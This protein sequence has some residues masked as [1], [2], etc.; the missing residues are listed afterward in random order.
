MHLIE[1]YF[2]WRNY[3]TAE[4]DAQSPFYGREYSEFEFHHKVYNYFIHP[5]WDEFGS[6]TLYA[7]IIFAD[8]DDSCAIVELIGEWNDTLYNDIMLFKR[9]L[10]DPMMKRGIHKFVLIGENVLNFH[11]SDDDYYM[12]WQEECMD[13]GGWIAAFNFQQH[14][15]EEMSQFGLYRYMF[16]DT[17]F[18]EVNWRKH[19][20]EHLVQ[21]T[22]QLILRQGRV[23]GF[24]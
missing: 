6:S 19:K 20:P 17:P 1:P 15:R 23:K 18:D 9:E 5:Q 21:I 13:E 8:Y 24:E 2:A 3:Y 22:E 10:I 14:V 12:E 4:T 16:Y 7:K 11:G